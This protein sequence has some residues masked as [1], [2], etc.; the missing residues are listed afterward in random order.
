MWGHFLRHGHNNFSSQKRAK[1]QGKK[2]AFGFFLP[3][4]RFFLCLGSRLGCFLKFWPFSFPTRFTSSFDGVAVSDFMV[5]NCLLVI[6]LERAISIA[7]SSVRDSSRES[8]RIDSSVSG[9]TRRWAFQIYVD[10][11]TPVFFANAS[12]GPYSNGKPERVKKR[13]GR[14]VRDARPQGVKDSR[15]SHSRITLTA[16]PAFRKRFCSQ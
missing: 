6:S 8:L 16:L 5:S 12:D 15:A 14:M 11:K 1:R 7:L 13:R 10:C 9:L 4:R 3:R 2:A